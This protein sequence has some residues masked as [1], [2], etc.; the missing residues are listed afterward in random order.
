VNIEERY[1]RNSVTAPRSAMALL[2][3]AEALNMRGYPEK[4]HW[5]PR[6]LLLGMC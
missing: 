2:E 4:R 5:T 3:L 6:D 1:S